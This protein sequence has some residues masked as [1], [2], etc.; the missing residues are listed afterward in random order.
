MGIESERT[1]RHRRLVFVRV[2]CDHCAA[3]YAR[4]KHSS[5]SKGCRHAESHGWDVSRY[6]PGKIFCVD[7]V[8]KH[9]I[10]PIDKFSFGVF[11]EHVNGT[12]P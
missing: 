9:S 8:K 10:K 3:V 7:C 6:Y 2:I 5:I 1:G 4:Q 12:E 11:E